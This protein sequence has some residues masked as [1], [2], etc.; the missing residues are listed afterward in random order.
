VSDAGIRYNALH[1]PLQIERH[2]SFTT[3]AHFTSSIILHRCEEFMIRGPL[4]TFLEH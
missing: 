2:I 1:D 4:Y 3:E